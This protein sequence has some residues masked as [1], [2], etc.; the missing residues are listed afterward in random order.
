MF[1]A[2]YLHIYRIIVDVITVADIN[3]ILLLA[4]LLLRAQALQS[5]RAL[6][7]VLEVGAHLKHTRKRDELKKLTV[8]R[9]SPKP[10][11][12]GGGGGNLHA[13]EGGLGLGEGGMIKVDIRTGN[14]GSNYNFKLLLN[15]FEL[16]AVNTTADNIVPCRTQWILIQL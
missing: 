7:D 12:V 4:L 15:R 14:V 2:S 11:E 5:L 16:A 8:L 9:P 6:V 3:G 13:V 1:S 10:G